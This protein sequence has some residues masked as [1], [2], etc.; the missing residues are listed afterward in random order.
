PSAARLAAKTFASAK[1][2]YE[3]KRSDF[4]DT[5]SEAQKALFEDK[6][7]DEAE[8]ILKKC[9]KLGLRVIPFSSPEMPEEVMRT[10]NPPCVLFVKGTAVFSQND[11]RVA[12]VGSRKATA[13][14]KKTAARIAYELAS[15]GITVVSGMAAGIDTAAH[16]GALYE[17]K[18][19]VAFLGGG[20][21]VIYPKENAE[22]YRH[23]VENGAVVS[24]YLPGSAVQGFHFPERNRLLSAFSK[25]VIIVES[26]ENSGSMRT[27]EHAKKQGVPV[28]A[29][30][31]PVD[32]PVS[33]G[34][35]R[36][37]KEGCRA[38]TGADDVIDF[39][40]SEYGMRLKIMKRLSSPLRTDAEETVPPEKKTEKQVKHKKEK[41][42][43]T[44]RKPVDISSLSE[45]AKAVLSFAEKRGSVA[46]DEICEELDADFGSA[47]EAVCEL[48][49]KEI[50][51][52]AEAG[53]YRIK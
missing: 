25:A 36:L 47:F 18:E 38:V 6:N 30:P 24:E 28:L 40:N 43:E 34:T 41:T 21:D 9:E 23:I 33:A 20:A 16:K 10:A 3:A 12:I 19:T 13:L 4:P 45:L 8:K 48:E 29:V 2:V 15:A 31:G 49:E 52:E 26:D 14:G 5:F 17:G 51:R 39:L 37:I 1:E 11:V 35:N 53:R 42:E 27:A 50:L 22:L 32:S 46:V 44:E 7:L